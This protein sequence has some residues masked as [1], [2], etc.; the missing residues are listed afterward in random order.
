MNDPTLTQAHRRQAAHRG[1]RRSTHVP[2]QRSPF[3]LK[4]PPAFMLLVIVCLASS[5][6]AIVIRLTG[7]VGS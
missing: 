7:V 4:V 3:E 1:R 2:T 6:A 5:V